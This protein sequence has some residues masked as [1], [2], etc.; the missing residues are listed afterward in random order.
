MR[1]DAMAQVIL[2]ASICGMED[3]P[4]Q[5]LLD[6]VVWN[7]IG[8]SCLTVTIEDTLAR[9]VL[10]DAHGE[11]EHIEEV[12]LAELDAICAATETGVDFLLSLD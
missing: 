8:K 11:T 2:H 4:S 3:E 7:G 6:R 12:A 9:F 10:L 1:L 5:Q